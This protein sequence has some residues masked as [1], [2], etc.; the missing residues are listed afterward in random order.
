MRLACFFDGI[1]VDA[2]NPPVSV[3]ETKM[4]YAIINPPCNYL[5]VVHAS[6]QVLPWLKPVMLG[7]A[8]PKWYQINW[9]SLEPD[10]NDGI[11]SLIR[12]ASSWVE[13][14]L[15]QNVAPGIDADVE[16]IR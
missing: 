2:N 14:S 10:G 13:I 9:S 3:E 15:E 4:R 7:T 11:L 5:S 12:S 8:E 16:K 6:T 1:S